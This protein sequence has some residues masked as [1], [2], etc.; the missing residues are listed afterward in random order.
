[1]RAYTE[2]FKIPG[3]TAFCVAGLVTRSGGSMMG[4]GL[5]LMVSAQYGSY[6]LAGGVAAANSVAWAVGAAA[7]SSLV[8]RHGQRRVMLPAALVSAGSLAA[9]VVLGS[10]SAPVWTLFPASVV[11]GGTAGAPGALVRSRWNHVLKDARKLHTAFSLESTLDE[12]TFVVGPVAATLLATQVA[13][14]AGLVAPIILMVAG[15]FWFYSLTATEP[16]VA[17]ASR[18][19]REPGSAGLL[20][21]MPGIATLAAVTVMVGWLFG[22][23]DVTVV[24]ATEAW[25]D[26][27]DAGLVLATVSLGS[28]LG[29]LGYGSRHWVS[30]PVRRWVIVLV[31]L[32]CCT[33]M[34]PLARDAWFLAAGGFA[35]GFTIAPTLIN[36]NTLMQSLAPPAR[37]T[38]GL[39]WISCSL[40]IGVSLGS[41]LAGQLID[42]VSHTA[43]FVT[44]VAAGAVASALALISAR[45]VARAL[46]R[47]TP[48]L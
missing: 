11:C 46:R 37:M 14:A 33:V 9:L 26:K 30:S 42:R 7:I 12:L 19:S 8:D 4:I 40:G 32:T 3:A 18:A 28:A 44:V 1:M 27:G 17:G 38:E 34:M 20:L 21:A 16:P 41:T 13:P 15:S 31:A 39:A 47:P 10:V 6:A 36:L 35:A 48:P 29:G 22:A 43:G 2:L 5:V 23:T 24:A 25:G 45:S